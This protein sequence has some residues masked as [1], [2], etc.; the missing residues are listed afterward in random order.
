MKYFYMLAILALNLAFGSAAQA[1]PMPHIHAIDDFPAPKDIDYAFDNK[2][3][4]VGVSHFGDGYRVTA[5]GGG[6]FTFIDP[7]IS[8]AYYGSDSSY[9]LVANFDASSNFVASGSTLTIFGTLPSIPQAAGTPSG[10]LYNADLTE[11]GY[12]ADQSAIAFR[13]KWNDDSAWANQPVLT[14]GSEGEAVYLFNRSGLDSGDGRLSSLIAALENNNLAEVV[15]KSFS[16]LESIATIPLPMPALLFAS[17]LVSILG[18][19][20]KRRLASV[21]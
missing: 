16:R 15:G 9:L 7:T 8:A 2:G 13:T 21:V 1:G 5:T 11:F 19:G 17:G 18:I 14:G 10:L 3:L 12:D 20:Q 4:V 6:E